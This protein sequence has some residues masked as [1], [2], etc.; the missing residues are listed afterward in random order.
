MQAMAD[1]PAELGLL[2]KI[3]VAQRS[4]VQLKLILSQLTG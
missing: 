1:I 4:F 2:L 3:D